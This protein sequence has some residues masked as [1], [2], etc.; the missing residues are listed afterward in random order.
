MPRET[1]SVWLGGGGHS[2]ELVTSRMRS[3]KSRSSRNETW[4]VGL[5][6]LTFMSCNVYQ[7]VA[8]RKYISW[9]TKYAAAL[10]Q[11]GDVPYSDAKLMTEDQIISLYRVD[12]NILHETNHPLRD[13]FWNL[14]PMLIQAHKEKTRHD[15]TVIAK[16]RRIRR[17][18]HMLIIGPEVRQELRE[19]SVEALSE[20]W[21]EAK[22]E[23]QQEANA[24]WVKEAN[25][26]G[27][28]VKWNA[29]ATSASRLRTGPGET[30]A[31]SSSDAEGEA[32]R[33]ARLKRKRRIPSRASPWPPKGSRPMRG[34]RH[35]P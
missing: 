23:G 31:T 4:T 15:A 27:G 13:S 32:S 19:G 8:R 24:A 33:S 14:T 1:I 3:T 25:R 28:A 9:K 21:R 18:G 34:K 2:L 7:G 29:A 17:R 5:S 12:H 22:Y 20:I 30:A 11:L 10:L 16:G 35:E 26:P 6:L